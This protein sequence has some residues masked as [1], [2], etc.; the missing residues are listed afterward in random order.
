MEKNNY[1]KVGNRIKIEGET[2]D[3]NVKKAILINYFAQVQPSFLKEW[4]EKQS[5]T[6]F[7]DMGKQYVDFK[8]VI[9][10]D[11]DNVFKHFN[12]PCSREF[13]EKTFDIWWDYGIEK[14]LATNY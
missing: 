7:I 9:M 8:K 2:T 11:Y 6:A 4:L 14:A 5:M 12:I 10:D 3:P 13:Y 1:T